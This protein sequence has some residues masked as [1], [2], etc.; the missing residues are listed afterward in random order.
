MRW[1][2]RLGCSALSYYYSISGLYQ[3]QSQHMLPN[4]AGT[5]TMQVGRATFPL[6]IDSKPDFPL[7]MPA[8]CTREQVRGD[9]SLLFQLSCAPFA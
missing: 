9:C 2:G 8:G 6:F 1:K 7:S 3:L 4:I 5:V